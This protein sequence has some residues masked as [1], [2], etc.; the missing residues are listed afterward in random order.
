MK[1][2]ILP[3]YLQC[4]NLLFFL[5]VYGHFNLFLYF[6]RVPRVVAKIYC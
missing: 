2:V 5:S 3:D 4:Y 6:G 1:Y